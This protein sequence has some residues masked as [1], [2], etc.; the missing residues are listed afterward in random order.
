MDLTH[1]LFFIYLPFKFGGRTPTTARR[2]ESIYH[3]LKLYIVCIAPELGVLFSE[4]FPAHLAALK[5]GEE[6]FVMGL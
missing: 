1:E 4:I 3:R 5:R 6:K 2:M